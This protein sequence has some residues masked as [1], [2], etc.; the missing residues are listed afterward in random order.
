VEPFIFIQSKKII[1]SY[2]THYYMEFKDW[3]FQLDLSHEH[4]A[5]IRILGLTFLYIGE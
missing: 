1:I 2:R 4:Y 3:L 5:Y